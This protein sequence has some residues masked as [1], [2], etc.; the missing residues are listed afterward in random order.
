MIQVDKMLRF[1]LYHQE[2][3]VNMKDLLEKAVTIKRLEYSPLGKELKAQTDIAKKQYQRL[4]D[5]HEFGKIIKKEKPK[6][7]NYSKPHLIYNS[8]C[9]FYKYYRDSTKFDNHAL[10]SKHSILAK[11]FNDFKKI[12][13]LNSKGQ[14]REN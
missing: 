4:D 8:N 9:R 14:K 6:R 11:F 2:M 13:R 1:L 12:N 7:E 5:T 10:E 3:L